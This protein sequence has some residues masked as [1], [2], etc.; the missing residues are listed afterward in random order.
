MAAYR[1]SLYCYSLCAVTFKLTSCLL[2]SSSA[3]FSPLTSFLGLLRTKRGVVDIG[4]TKAP[5]RIVIR[6]L[7][8]L[9]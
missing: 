2:R 6:V 8:S 9:R 1:G 5:K 3:V 7:H 4:H